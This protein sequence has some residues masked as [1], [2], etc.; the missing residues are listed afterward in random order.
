MI[1]IQYSPIAIA[2]LFLFVREAPE[3]NTGLRVEGIQKWSGGTRGDSWCC[4]FAT[5]VLDICFQ[6][7]SPIP[8]TGS[9]QEVYDLAKQNGWVTD[10]P[11]VGDLF[12]YVNADDH[13]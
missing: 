8:R 6:G 13:A 5:L 11:S 3:Q 9:C 12:L 7:N 1:A 2:R 4:E 10:K